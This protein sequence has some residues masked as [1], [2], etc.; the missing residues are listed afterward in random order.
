MEAKG[1]RSSLSPSPSI[2][3]HHRIITSNAHLQL[4]SFEMGNSIVAVCIRGS[5]L[6]CFH[7]TCK[8]ALDLAKQLNLTAEFFLN[9]VDQ[10]MG[11]SFTP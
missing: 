4:R 10:K 9:E 6:F 11:N 5:Q 7:N 8:P 1:V 3:S 2:I